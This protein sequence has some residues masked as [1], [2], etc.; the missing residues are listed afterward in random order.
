MFIVK[1]CVFSINFTGWEELS[2]CSAANNCQEN[3]AQL[4]MVKKK[5][6]EKMLCFSR[7]KKKA[8]P[9]TP[10]SCD[11]WVRGGWQQRTRLAGSKR[12][13]MID[14]IWNQVSPQIWRKYSKRQ[15]NP[16]TWELPRIAGNKFSFNMD[17]ID[18]SIKT[19]FSW[20]GAPLPVPAESKQQKGF[21]PLPNLYES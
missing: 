16:N 18:S 10:M 4:S 12:F 8:F 1:I 15:I 2:L 17:Y 14:L 20:T 21:P 3:L 19:V 9:G 13:Q 6:L 5:L 7:K 11:S